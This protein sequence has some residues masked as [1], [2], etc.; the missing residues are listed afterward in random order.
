[1]ALGRFD[2]LDEVA[3]VIAFLAS[4]AA[5][6]ILGAEIVVDGGTIRTI[7][8]PARRRLSD[9]RHRHR[10]RPRGPARAGARLPRRARREP[11]RRRRGRVRAGR[12]RPRRRED[13]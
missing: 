7:R 2:T 12:D 3:G 11:L 13:L 10:L 9:E 8:P 4:D 6:G 5:A 1:M